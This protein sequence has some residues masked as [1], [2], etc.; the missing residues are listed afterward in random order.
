LPVRVVRAGKPDRAA[1]GPTRET[2]VESVRFARIVDP[3]LRAADGRR[4]PAGNRRQPI[5]ALGRS[6]F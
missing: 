4:H 3:V 6:T 5:A 1:R 2:E